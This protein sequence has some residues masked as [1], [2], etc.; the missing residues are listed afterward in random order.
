MY[1]ILGESPSLAVIYHMG[2]REALH[3]PK[4]FEKRLKDYF[5]D[6]ANIILKR[7]L[8]NLKTH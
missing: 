8:K 6:G 5:G 2:G 7:I 3:D 1:D 4:V